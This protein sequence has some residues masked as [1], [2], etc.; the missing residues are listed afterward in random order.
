MGSDGKD[1]IQKNKFNGKTAEPPL[2]AHSG[3]LF[4]FQ[5]VIQYSPGY[6]SASG[7]TVFHLQH[8][9]DGDKIRLPLAADTE[10]I[11]PLEV[12]L[13]QDAEGTEVSVRDAHAQIVYSIA[14][15]V[16]DLFKSSTVPQRAEIHP[17][18]QITATDRPCTVGIPPLQQNVIKAVAVEVAGTRNLSIVQDIEVTP[19]H[20]T[21]AVKL[22]DAG[23]TALFI[24]QHH[25]VDSVMVEIADTGN[26]PLAAEALEVVPADI[27]TVGQIRA[28]CTVVILEQKVRN[29]VAVEIA[30]SENMRR[31]VE[32]LDLLPCSHAGS[33]IKLQMPT[34][35]PFVR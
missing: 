25:I 10:V 24:L 30:K 16:A 34:V 2:S 15:E 5:K 26:A 29:A 31:T 3:K 4:R 14:V 23:I 20:L 27:L 22:P 6:I 12:A 19:A 17:A 32:T 21:I 8:H 9:S 33:F 18:G 13:A 11:I 7:G 35:S 1:K 28:D